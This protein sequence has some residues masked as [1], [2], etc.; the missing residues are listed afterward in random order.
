MIL[1]QIWITYNLG[2][3][4]KGRPQNFAIFDAPPPVSAKLTFYRW[5]LTHASAFAWPPPSVHRTSFMDAPYKVT[6][7][8]IMQIR[9]YHQ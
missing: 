7:D 3:I 9:L 5:N 4:H 2:D 8:E 6:S 1:S